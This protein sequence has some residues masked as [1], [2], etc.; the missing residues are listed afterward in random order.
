MTNSGVDHHHSEAVTACA[1]FLATTEPRARPKPLV[2]AMKAM[3]GLSA[4][5]VCDAIRE[6]HRILA[7][8]SS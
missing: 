5:E 8:K 1:N 6:S 4:L 7:E 3:F 2:P